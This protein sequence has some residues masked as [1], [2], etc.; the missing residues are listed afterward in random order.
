MDKLVTKLVAKLR[1]LPDGALVFGFILLV[2][3]L[4]AALLSG[5]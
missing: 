3:L 4:L 1:G 5:C 2:L